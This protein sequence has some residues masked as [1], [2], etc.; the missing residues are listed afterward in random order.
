MALSMGNTAAELKS[1]LKSGHVGW[2][3]NEDERGLNFTLGW[4]DST[5]T[6]GGQIPIDGI[7]SDHGYLDTCDNPPGPP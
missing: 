2:M 1:K 3:G 5:R 4:M 6:M 7:H